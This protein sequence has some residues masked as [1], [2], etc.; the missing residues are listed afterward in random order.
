MPI[1]VIGH[2]HTTASIKLREKF[3]FGPGVLGAA[4]EQLKLLQKIHEGVIVSTCNRNEIYGLV[5]DAGKG[6]LTLKDFLYDFH[7]VEADSLDHTLYTYQDEKAVEHLFEVVSGIDSLIVGETQV[8]AQVKDA[9]QS[10]LESEAT[11]V[12]LN[13][14]F[15]HGFETGKKARHFTLISQGAVSVSFAAVQLA[16]KI[17]QNM[18]DKTVLLIGAGETGELTAR[19]LIQN[20][21]KEFIVTNRTYSRAE[22]LARSL[23]GR[24]LHFDRLQQAAEE[25]DIIVSA[26]A[27]E[28]HVISFEQA[29]RLMQRRKNSPLFIID[30][31][32]PRDVAPEVRKLYNVFLYN[33]DDLEDI[34]DENRNRRQ[35]EVEKVRE[36][37]NSQVER[38]MRWYRSLEVT[39][40]I[41]SLRK[42]FDTI[43]R[44]E[45]KRHQKD[46]PP[47]SLDQ[48]DALTLAIINKLLHT[49]STEI[50]RAMQDGNVHLRTN[51]LRELF[52]L[53]DEDD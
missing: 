35:T 21:A 51:V 25:A 45:L 18:E 42:H 37:V 13:R 28:E 9:Y 39:P 16:K 12:V 40:T 48:V 15:H 6:F 29:K 36:I 2:N 38:F 20:G 32:V 24:A 22:E 43:R 14:L 7:N 26:T 1:V 11:G 4:L 17:Y 10:A 3:I 33:V 30:L 47:D 52:H 19:N 27:H 23:R 31:A 50:K 8:M 41:V 5:S 53:L 49:P 46:I 44:N 34:A